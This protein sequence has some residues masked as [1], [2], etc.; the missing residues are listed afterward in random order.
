MHIRQRVLHGRP[1]VDAAT[2]FPDFT[3]DVVL[4]FGSVSVFAQTGW[5]ERLRA[6]APQACWIGCSTAGEIAND[7]VNDD[8]CVL[9]ALSFQR[10]ASAK[11][12]ATAMSC[13]DDSE[14]AGR[15]LGEALPREGL[16]GVFVLGRGVAINGSSLVAGLQQVLGESVPLSGGLAGD[17]GAFRQTWTLGPGGV[18][19]DAVVALGLYGDS[20]VL[21]N[22][23]Y[24]GWEPFGPARRV[25][26]CDNNILY[27]LDD[28]PALEIYKR[29]LG[30]HARGLPA[31][32]LLFPFEMLSR[33][34]T[35]GGIIRTILG[36][37][38]ANGSLTLAGDID[39]EGYLRLMH[40]STDRLVDGAERAA[41]AVSDA[42]AAVQGDVLALLVSC[43]GRRLVMGERVDEE[44]GGVLD[45][46]GAN[47]TATGFYSNG[48]IGRTLSDGRCRL[49]NQT[50]TVTLVGER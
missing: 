19:D 20:I 11:A 12:V 27:A 14:A 31:S 47:V 5:L 28:E 30:E 18:R 8:S 2:L 23:S 38:E 24:G 25:T 42:G 33:G 17:G 29:Y 13:M 46:L 7:E 41:D 49:H 40:S 44:T 37:D 34:Q 48:E 45:V 21:D 16:R 39:P 10:G 3:P 15:R 26:R 35:S 4:A 50:M 43:V 6:A 36:V 9:T 32:G 22:G 1:T